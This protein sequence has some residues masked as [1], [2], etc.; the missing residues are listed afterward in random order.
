[1]DKKSIEKQKSFIKILKSLSKEVKIN[2]KK[3]IPIEAKIEV[4][5]TG[6]VE[7]PT[8]CDYK[9]FYNLGG[10]DISLYISFPNNKTLAQAMSANKNE[11]NSTTTK[12]A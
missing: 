12:S 4:V 6:I 10:K 9:T 1:M 7:D 8:N 3:G 2:L 5:A 11:Q